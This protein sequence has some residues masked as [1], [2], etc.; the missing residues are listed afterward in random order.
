MTKKQ[1]SKKKPTNPCW[2]CRAE[3]IWYADFTRDDFCLE[4]EGQ[5]TILHCSGC[6]SEVRYTT[7]DEEMD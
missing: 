6:G 4:G 5:V 1:A 2:L 3:L 7:P